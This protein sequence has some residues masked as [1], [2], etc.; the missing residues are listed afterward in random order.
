MLEFILKKGSLFTGIS[1]G[2]SFFRMKHVLVSMLIIAM[3]GCAGNQKRGIN[4]VGSILLIHGSAPFNEDGNVPDSRAG[5][6]QKT[7]FYLKLARSLETNGWNVVRY[8]KPGVSMEAVDFNEYSKTDI[9][10]SY[11]M[12]MLTP[13]YRYQ[14]PMSG[15]SDFRQTEFKF[16]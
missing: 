3:L 2:V 12:V 5:R 7:D 9:R 13:R 8:S 15:K 16:A 6:Y 11:F 14:R 1:P 10:F 4:S